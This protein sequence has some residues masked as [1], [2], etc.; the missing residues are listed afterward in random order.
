MKLAI[1]GRTCFILSW[2]IAIKEITDFAGSKYPLL[3]SK[4]AFFT[5][6]RGKDNVETRDHIIDSC[7]IHN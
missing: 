2:S 4:V 6:M 1:N 5:C 3:I 7:V